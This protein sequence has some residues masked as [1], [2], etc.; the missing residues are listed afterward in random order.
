MKTLDRYLIRTFL[1]PFCLCL[2]LM[3]GLFVLIDLF[4]NLDHFLGLG[5]FSRTGQLLLEYYAL[6]SVSFL[7]Q[8][9]PFVT[10][11]AGVLALTRLEKHQELTAIRAAGVSLHRTVVSLLI[12]AL[13]VSLVEWIVQEAVIPRLGVRLMGVA[14]RLEALSGRKNRP[15][16]DLFLM[17]ERGRRRRI[18]HIGELLYGDKQSEIRRTLIV[19]A[20]S[21]RASPLIQVTKGVW[22]ERR[23]GGKKR[24]FVTGI[25]WQPSADGARIDFEA[26]EDYM[27]KSDVTPENMIEGGMPSEFQTFRQLRRMAEHHPLARV[28]LHARLAA[29]AASFLL[30]LVGIPLVLREG[31]HSAILGAGTAL[32]VAVI[33]Y[34]AN[35][36]MLDLGHRGTVDAFIAAWLPVVGFGFLGAFLFWRMGT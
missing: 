26:W 9:F 12:C 2:V 33:F 3:V 7:P 21:R 32:L 11:M 25:L 17:E 18:W 34:G 20:G 19:E 6:K 35:I 36:V 23:E 22:K 10:L 8:L 1:A 30:L 15:Y 31:A 24:W 13:S 27:F 29:P 5:D 16:R 14:R 28:K 4:E